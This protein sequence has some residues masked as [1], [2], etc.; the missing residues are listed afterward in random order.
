MLVPLSE[1]ADPP[2]GETRSAAS[3]PSSRCPAATERPLPINTVTFRWTP[4]ILQAG[5]GRLGIHRATL[6]QLAPPGIRRTISSGTG[7]DV[8][9]AR[10]PKPLWISDKCELT[11]PC[12][13][14]LCGDSV[15]VMLLRRRGPSAPA[16]ARAVGFFMTVVSMK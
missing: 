4:Q 10:W 8:K 7:A 5:A 2:P 3:T 15:G 11:D 16:R 12:S 14:A 13:P 6:A 9:P 1:L